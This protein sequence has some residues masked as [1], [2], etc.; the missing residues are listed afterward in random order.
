MRFFF[1]RLVTLFLLNA[2]AF[3]VLAAE[4]PSDLEKGLRVLLELELN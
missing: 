1:M 3:S 2:L 4:D